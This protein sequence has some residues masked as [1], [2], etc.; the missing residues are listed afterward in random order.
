MH[1]KIFE[2]W[3]FCIYKLTLN[4]E[5]NSPPLPPFGNYYSQNKIKEAVDQFWYYVMFK[6][7]YK[8]IVV[9][10]PAVYSDAGISFKRPKGKLQIIETFKIRMISEG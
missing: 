5:L 1:G 8:G 6:Q 9:N 7:A 2:S 4:L 10:L 3:R